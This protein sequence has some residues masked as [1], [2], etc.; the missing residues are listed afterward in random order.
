MSTKCLGALRSR[1]QNPLETLTLFKSLVKIAEENAEPLEDLAGIRKSPQTPNEI[2]TNK[3][4]NH[5]YRKLRSTPKHQ[6]GLA[7]TPMN[8]E[9]TKIQPELMEDLAAI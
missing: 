9:D 4:A 6:Q 1:I 3:R 8:T 5:F 7:K 2:G